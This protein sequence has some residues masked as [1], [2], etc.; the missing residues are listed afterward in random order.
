MKNRKICSSCDGHKIADAGP[1]GSLP[2]AEDGE[3]DFALDVQVRIEPHPLV[4]GLKLHL[5]RIVLEPRV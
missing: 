5:R 3:A 4:A 1:A 2:R